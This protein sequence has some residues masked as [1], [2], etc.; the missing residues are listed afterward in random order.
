VQQ[1]A[2]VFGGTLPDSPL[3][4]VADKLDQSLVASLREQME[5]GGFVL[6]LLRNQD[7]V[8][9]AAALAGEKGWIAGST[10]RNDALLGEIDFQHPLFAPFADP[11]FSNFTQI[12]F[13]KP[14]P[15][16]MPEDTQAITVARF[17]DTSPAVVEV[18]VG[19][20][21]LIV[22]GDGW[23]TASGQ[24][25]LSSKFVPWLQGLVERSIGGP[26]RPSL[27]DTSDIVHL[28]GGRTA[29]WR[30]AKAEA[31]MFSD[32][33]PT[34]P[35]LYQ[36]RQG[37]STRWVALHVPPSESK[38]EQ[39]ELDTWEQLGVPL[40]V[41]TDLKPGITE[42]T[43]TAIGPSTMLESEQ[44]FWRWLLIAGIVV[45]AI[46]SLAAARVG[47]RIATATT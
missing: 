14:I 24:W 43:K 44:Q 11:R 47:R 9:T 20:G 35:G 1:F 18:P 15:I 42:T 7:M 32:E 28:T 33:A 13:W 17:D 21:R 27:A 37:E 5:R 22:W 3:T 4:I 31:G 26:T 12:R 38:N 46:E 10:E 23:S 30:D 41:E 40:H 39:L 6:V 34:A 2:P 25:V 36:L 8:S 16:E 29:Q 19:E 45:L